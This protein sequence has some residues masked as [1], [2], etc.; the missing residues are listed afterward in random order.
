MS[1]T[2]KMY[3][4]VRMATFKG[5]PVR[6]FA[7]FDMRNNTIQVSNILPFRPSNDVSEL[8]QEALEKR[9]AAKK[10]T[11]IITDCPD[12]FDDYDI[13]FSPNDHLDIAA[14]AYINYNRQGV[15]IID[16]E[17]KGR[18]NVENV[19]D[20][21][22]LELGKGMVYQLDPQTTNNLHVAVLGLCYGAKR[23]T[24][25]ANVLNILDRQEEQEIH[26]NSVMPFT[27]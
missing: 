16:N 24:G 12:A 5:D 27:I 21:K 26:D 15:L 3:L 9:Q 13:A 17:L 20:A 14:L 4:D 25:G 2:H 1:N 18:A 10:Q 22:K 19:L 11:L 7:A 8:S 23:A 6:I